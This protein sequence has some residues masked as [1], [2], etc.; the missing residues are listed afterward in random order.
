MPVMRRACR[1]LWAL[2]LPLLA[3]CSAA[4]YY[5]QA[6]YGHFTLL[7]AARPIPQW[8]QNPQTPEPLKERLRL[9]QRIRLYA[10]ERLHLPDNASY[11]NYAA[12]Q[13]S[14]AVWNVV[15]APPDSL[16][17]KRWCYLV[18]GCVSYRGYYKYQGAQAL[19]ERLRERGGL[20]VKVYGVPAY[21]TLGWLNWLGGDPLLSTV[22]H[23]PEG[24]L[25][26]L[27]FHELAHQTVY[28]A[29][30]TPFNEAYANAVGYLGVRQWLNEQ[31]DEAARREYD[32]LAARRRDFLELV[33]QTRVELA[34]VYGAA[35]DAQADAALADNKAAAMARFRQ[36]YA[37][38]KARW[39]AA[40][41][42]FD[43][44]D[45]W[46]DEAN[47]A[48]FGL[49]ATYDDWVPVF[50]VIF[51]CVAEDWPSFHAVA[52]ALADRPE[53]ERRRQLGQWLQELQAPERICQDVAGE[54][55]TAAQ[56]AADAAS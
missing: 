37:M 23:R 34:R 48:S 2:L 21:S 10:S 36:R 53:P 35:A 38:L 25:A 6:V 14:A 39:A 24:E 3:G 17:L 13:R 32:V 18:A 15:A 44:Y 30:D 1:W 26:R 5:G 33:R 27:M 40:G 16:Q 55:M 43:G 7:G 31:A 52:Q 12:L 9:A 28:A 8:L 51:G 56:A 54:G 29:G 45:A 42:P 22:I 19:A 49:Q 4:S 20:E 41:M 47:N 46:V 11:H 50:E